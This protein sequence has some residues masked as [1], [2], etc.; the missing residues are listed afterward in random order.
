MN[1]AGIKYFDIANA[2]GIGLS[3]FVS[4]CPHHCEGCFNKEAWDY[5]FGE[6]Y[7]NETTSSIVEC[8]KN[9]P[10]VTSFSLLGG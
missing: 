8:Y 9:N 4:G 2:P 1:Y 7:T 3:L 6:L 10:Q 5:N